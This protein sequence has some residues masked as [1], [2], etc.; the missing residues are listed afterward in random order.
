MTGRDWVST[1]RSRHLRGRPVRDTAPELALRR[2]LHRQGLRYRLG[3]SLDRAC[4]PDILFV[5]QRLAI[6]VDGCYWHGHEHV[7]PV[8]HGPNVDLWRDKIAENKRRDTEAVRR[9][10]QLGYTPLRV[11]ECEIAS[12]VDQVTDR[13]RNQLR[14]LS[15]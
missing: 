14:E 9:A 7:A 10:Q 1:E 12:D 8:S 6:W 5:R 4:N 11:W 2:S 13:I 15:L 3:V